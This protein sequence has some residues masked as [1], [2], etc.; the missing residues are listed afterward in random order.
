[1]MSGRPGGSLFF[2]GSRVAKGDAM[3]VDL[4]TFTVIHVVI[5]LFVW[6]GLAAVRGFRAAHAGASPAAVMRT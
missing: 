5:S 1:M 6:L 2:A 4:Q 3:I